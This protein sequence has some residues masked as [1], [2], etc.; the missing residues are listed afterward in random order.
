MEK[1]TSV[2]L[3]VGAEDHKAP[4]GLSW[5]CGVEFV[6]FWCFSFMVFSKDRK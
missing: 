6:T 5:E 1:S 4:K 2:S 3:R